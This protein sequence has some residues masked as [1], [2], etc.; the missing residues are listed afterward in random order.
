MI[1]PFKFDLDDEVFI[2]DNVSQHYHHSYWMI[3]GR[4]RIVRRRYEEHFANVMSG[5]SVSKVYV[6]EDM[7]E[8]SYQERFLFAKKEDAQ[9]E[10]DFKN[11]GKHPIY[12]KGEQK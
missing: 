12:F 10:C 1:E 6:L 9:H 2:I 4:G 3:V 7:K 11:G 8:D 5:R